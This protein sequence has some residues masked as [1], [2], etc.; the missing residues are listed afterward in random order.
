[1]EKQKKTNS[2]ELDTYKKRDLLGWKKE[3][4]KKIGKGNKEEKEL[5]MKHHEIL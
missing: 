5:N 3:K 4:R 1:M 2:A